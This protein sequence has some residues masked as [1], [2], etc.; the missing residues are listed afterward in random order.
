M[1]D[2]NILMVIVALMVLMV[3]F[4]GGSVF[5]WCLCSYSWRQEIVGKGYAEWQIVKGTREVEFKWKE[6]Q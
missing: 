6:K 5:G 3:L 2:D 1:N 4:V